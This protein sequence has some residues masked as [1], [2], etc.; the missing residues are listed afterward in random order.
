MAENIDG[1]LTRVVGGIVALI[2]FGGVVVF[3]CFP[4]FMW[5]FIAVAWNAMGGRS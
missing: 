3:V 2:A 5:L 4:L 1:E